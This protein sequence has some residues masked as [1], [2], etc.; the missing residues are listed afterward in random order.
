MTELQK[1]TIDKMD[2]H[3][4]LRLWRHAPSGTSDLLQ[5]ECGA[6]FGKVM[7]EK[8][9]ALAPGEAVAISKQIGW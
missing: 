4:M 5:G 6:Y 8:K 2:Y 7:A 3:D 1:Q 9:A